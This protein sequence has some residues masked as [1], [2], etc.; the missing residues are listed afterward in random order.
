MDDFERHLNLDLQRLL[1][2]IVATPA[3]RRRRSGGG[4]PLRAIAG[5]LSSVAGEVPVLAEPAPATV[6]VP[7]APLS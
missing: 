5:G 2:P 3:P 1:D 6:P 7:A 4:N